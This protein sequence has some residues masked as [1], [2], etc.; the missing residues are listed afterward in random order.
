MS[1]K[2]VETF[3]FFFDTVVQ[4]SLCILEPLMMKSTRTVQLDE[5]Q[6]LGCSRAKN[7][8]HISLTSQVVRWAKG[9]TC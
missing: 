8:C 7:F 9:P 3:L 6:Q 5:D 1:H 2:Y 4:M